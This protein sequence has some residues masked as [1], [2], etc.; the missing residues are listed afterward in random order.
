MHR[1]WI[2]NTITNMCI[3]TFINGYDNYSLSVKNIT[4]FYCN[5]E[6]F[7]YSYINAFFSSQLKT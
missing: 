2:N 3:Q 1:S 5:L 4:F 7:S 6:I